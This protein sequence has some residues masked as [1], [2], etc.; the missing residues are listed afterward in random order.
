MVF[1][2]AP[3]AIA[4]LAVIALAG[5]FWLWFKADSK[6]ETTQIGLWFG[7]GF[8][9][10]GVSWLI[11]SMYIYANVNLFLAVLATFIFIL[12]LSLYFMLAGWLVG[13]LKS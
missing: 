5:L 3:V 8:F 11:S 13:L 6:K 7:L 9:G 4:P 10:V 1:A 2:H 12:F